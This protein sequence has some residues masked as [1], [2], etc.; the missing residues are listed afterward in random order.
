MRLEIIREAK[1][2]SRA[3]CKFDTL[4]AKCQDLKHIQDFEKVFGIPPTTI[5]FGHNLFQFC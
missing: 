5:G 4:I 1:C 3:Q 2:D